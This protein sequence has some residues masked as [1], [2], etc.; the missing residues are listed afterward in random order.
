MSHK[1]Y[2]YFNYLLSKF[3]HNNSGLEKSF[4]RH[5]HWGYWQNPLLANGNDE[6]FAIAAENL[7]RNICDIA[8]I[9][10]H[11]SVLDAGCGFGGTIAYLNENFQCMDLTGINI[12]KRQ[13]DRAE[14]LVSVAPGNK[15][16]FTEAD[17]CALPD[18]DIQFDRILAV[19]CIFHFS[20]RERFFEQSQHLLK[21]GGSLTISD[22]IPA[23]F[24]LPIAWL[25]SVQ[26]IQKFSFFGSCN[27]KYTLNKYKRLADRYGFELMA[28]DITIHTLP[29]YD[30][31]ETIL[32][33]STNSAY[34]TLIAN[35]T[36]HVTQFISRHG[37]LKYQILNFKKL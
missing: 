26:P 29:T 32:R 16:T 1:T 28:S 31:L 22:F 21:T 17:A 30:Y 4:G 23:T 5:V 14:K 20:S 34:L 6:D 12:D 35:V 33:S 10:D 25:L 13:L 3:E 15:I 24:F 27:I 36:L 37:F 7:T 8:D 9:R 11:Q 2:P 19:E 18:D